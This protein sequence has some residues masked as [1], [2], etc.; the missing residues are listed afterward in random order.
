M[1][2]NSTAI[3]TVT[4]LAAAIAMGGGLSLLSA[5]NVIA[6]M[7]GN[8]TDGTMRPD[9]MMGM[10]PGMMDHGMGMM[11]PGMM[12]M[13]SGTMDHGMGMMGHGIMW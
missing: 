5:N 9:G 8:M 6:Q 10:G 12:G 13:G 2:P 4:L 11:G 3:L 7:P 1:E